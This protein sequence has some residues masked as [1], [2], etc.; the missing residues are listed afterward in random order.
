[1]WKFRVGATELQKS[2]RLGAQLSQ[3][4]VPREVGSHETIKILGSED[5]SNLC[6]SSF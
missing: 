5:F 2:V 3:G 1:M 6:V 4:K